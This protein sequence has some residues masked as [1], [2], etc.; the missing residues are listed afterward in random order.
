MNR[1]KLLI[2]FALLL[3][4]SIKWLET[5]AQTWEEFFRQKETQRDYLILQIGALEI[6]SKLLSES[7]SIF[8][9][10]LD[11]VGSWKGLEKEI[12]RTHFD[13]FKRLGP[14]SRAAYEHLMDSGISPEGLLSRIESSR[15]LW[16]RSELDGDFRVGNSTIHEGLKRR[17]LDRVEELNLMLGTELEMADG[18]RA[19]EI[20]KV[21]SG[22]KTIQE[23][24][25]RLQ[26]WSSHRLQMNQ[27]KVKWMVE[28]S[29]Y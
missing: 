8:R 20:S 16:D 28:P 26:V 11:A 14:L 6:Q 7:A 10:G 17:C 3:T 2:M 27:Q 25:M 29:K 24:L 9:L 4:F 1:F 13:S 18:D 12:H 5:K 23:D 21:E 22:L 15:R 19:K